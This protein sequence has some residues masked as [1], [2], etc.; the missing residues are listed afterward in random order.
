[1]KILKFGAVW[2]NGCLVMRPRFSQIEKEIPWLKTQYIDFDIDKQNVDKYKINSGVLPV[3]IFLNK[4]E[5]EILRLSGEIEK[6]EL[7][8]VITDHKD[9]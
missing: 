9:D 4:K 8:K 3:F 7:I 6:S 5:Q 1:M 2:C